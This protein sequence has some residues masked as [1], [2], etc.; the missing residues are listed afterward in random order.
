MTNKEE[1]L[2]SKDHSEDDVNMILHMLCGIP[3]SGKS[4]LVPRLKG[5]V[6]S[7][8]GIRKYLWGDESVV[9]HDRLVFRIADDIINY[10]L[11]AGKNVIFDATNLTADR[12]MKYVEMAGRH[13]APVV[14]HWVKCPLPVAIERNLKRERKVPVP[15]IKALYDSFQE[16]TNQEGFR[17]VKVYGQESELLKVVVGDLGLTRN[18][19]K[20]HV[21]IYVK[22]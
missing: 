19:L 16:P 11:S 12:R 3:G 2:L 14:L 4:T 18:R 21:S 7:T 22:F 5:Y 8:D 1:Y 17:V 20:L 10:Q 9:K 6:V 15:V 13:Q